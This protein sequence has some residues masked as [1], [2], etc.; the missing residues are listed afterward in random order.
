[1]PPLAK[2]EPTSLHN[3]AVLPLHT[4]LPGEQTCGLHWPASQNVPLPHGWLST[5]YKPSWL[6]TF[7][8]WPSQNGWPAS[9]TIGWQAPE[10][11]LAALAAQSVD[12]S[13][14]SPSPLHSSAL[15]P[16]H[17][18]PGVHTHGLQSGLPPGATHVLCAG[19]ATGAPKPSPTALHVTLALLLQ[20]PWPCAQTSSTHWPV[21]STPTFWQW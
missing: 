1:M 2:P 7:L 10:T 20:A 4:A 18:T 3:V 15:L 13:T 5:T 14:S 12:F 11:H 19:H 8:L 9:H 6:Q 17:D 16:S 21:W